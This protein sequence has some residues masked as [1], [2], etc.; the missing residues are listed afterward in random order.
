MRVRTA[1]GSG[2]IGYR[3][4]RRRHDFGYPHRD[5]NPART[6]M[7]WVL[8]ALAAVACIVFPPAAHAA[9]APRYALVVQ[10]A[11]P[12]RSGARSAGA[13]ERRWRR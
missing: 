2:Q 5:G 6:L 11:L 10:D 9:P 3:P 7:T 4:T 12:L 13:P 1:R 8:A